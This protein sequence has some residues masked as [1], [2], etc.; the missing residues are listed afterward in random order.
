MRIVSGSCPF[1]PLHFSSLQFRLSR[2]VILYL[3]REVRR[4][5]TWPSEEPKNLEEEW[6]EKPF[7]ASSG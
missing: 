6:K 5:Q 1:P 4:K 2:R 7:P 3:G